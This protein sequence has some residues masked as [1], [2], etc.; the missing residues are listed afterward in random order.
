M[1]AGIAATA[2]LLLAAEAASAARPLDTGLLDSNY[3]VPDPE[4]EA[5]LFDHTV[6]AGARFAKISVGWRARVTG[7]PAKPK[8]P[9]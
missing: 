9:R 8:R 3:G 5:F 2:A 6:A 1:L 7:V 4:A